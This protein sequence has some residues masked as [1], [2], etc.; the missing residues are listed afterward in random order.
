ME[1]R[2][3]L[4]R[5]RDQGNRAWL[6]TRRNVNRAWAWTRRN[7]SLP[8]LT[9]ALVLLALAWS[10]YDRD[11]QTNH[12]RSDLRE[13]RILVVQILGNA[14]CS[15]ETG[16]RRKVRAL[17]RSGPEQSRPFDKQLVALGFPSYEER[18]AQADDQADTLPD[19]PC[20]TIIARAVKASLKP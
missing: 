4:S 15:G 1:R 9:L 7:I 10:Y 18:K 6:W 11:N 8:W 14:L 17:I 16:T 12:R 3:I 19:L 13:S 2:R 5:I 20:R